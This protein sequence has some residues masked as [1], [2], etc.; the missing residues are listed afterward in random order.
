[1]S[2]QYKVGEYVKY[3]SNG[4]CLI[5]DIQYMSFTGDSPTKYYILSP[6]SNLTTVIYVPL[7]NEALTSK[8]R[9]ILTKEEIDTVLPN[10]DK[11]KISWMENRKERV[12]RFQSIISSGD[13][14]WLLRL[15]ACLYQ[16]KQQV[17]KTGK[18]FSLTDENFLQQSERIIENEFSFVLG[19]DPSKVKEYIQNKIN[20]A[21]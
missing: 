16:R 11:E 9:C 4:V 14:L 19:I 12:E 17:I 2:N 10:V 3:S 13:T 1:M 6:R 21:T 20:G 8:M 7:E 5:K 15:V 18:K